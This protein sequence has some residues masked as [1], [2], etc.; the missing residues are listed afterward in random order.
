MVIGDETLKEIGEFIILLLVHLSFISNLVLMIVIYRKKQNSFVQV[1][2]FTLA[3]TLMIWNLGT[4]L[5]LDYRLITGN[6][7]ASTISIM[8][9]DICYLAI[10]FEPIVILFLGRVIYQHDWHP[11]MKHMALFIIPTISFMMVCTNPLHN[12]FFKNFSLYSSEAV[13]GPYYYF[14]SLYSYGCIL[15]GLAF[16]VVFAFR[17]SGILSKQFFMIVF[18]IIIPLTGNVLFSFGFADL[19]FS[20]NACLFTV[21][22]IC[23]FVAIFKY[24]FFAVTPIDM[25]QVIDLI[26]EGFLQTDKSMKIVDYNNMLISL[27]PNTTLNTQEITLDEFFEQ[28]ELRSYKNECEEL[29]N[30]SKKNRASANIH[31]DLPDSNHFT[32]QITPFFNHD[33]YTGSIV[34]FKNIMRSKPE[35]ETDLQNALNKVEENNR[36]LSVKIEENIARF[37]EDRQASQAIYD[38]NPQINFIIDLEYNIIDCNPAALEFYKFANKDELKK[39]VIPMLNS[40]IPKKMPN[41]A[42]SIPISKRL[43]DAYNLGETSFDTL[44]LFDGEEIPFHFDLKRVQYKNAGVIAVYQTDLRELKKIEK[45]LEQRDMLLSAINTVSARL[46][47]VENEDFDKSFGESIAMLGRSIDVERVVVWKNFERDGA[48]YCTQIHEWCE[49]AERQHGMPHT[50]NIKYSDTVPTWETTLRQGKCVNSISKNLLPIEKA[51][52]ELQGI[53]SVLAVPLFVR[54]MFW[55]FVGFDDC[56]NERVFSEM[57]ESTLGSGAML[58]AAAL[59]RNEMTNN[60]IVAKDDALSSARAKSTFLANMSHEIRTP[61]NAIIGMTTIAKNATSPQK[62]S[63]CLSE[64]SIASTHLL[65]VINDILDVSKIEAE[66][67]ELAR[68]EFDFMETIK[69]ITTITAESIKRKKQIFEIDC[70]PNIPKRLIGDDLRFSQIITNFLSNAI[71]FTP[72]HGKIGLE[73]KLT[74]DNGDEVELT[75]A[76]TDTGIGISPEQQQ[77]L[78]AAFEQADRSTSRKYGGTGLGLVIS[79]NIIMQMGGNVKVTSEIGKGSR[80]EFNVFLTKGSDDEAYVENTV[81]EQIEKFDYTGKHILLVEDVDINREII[82]ALL[83]DTNITIDCAENGLAGAEKFLANQDKY[84]LIF[85][86]IQM[87]LMDGFDATKKIRAADTPKAKSVPIVAMTANAFKEDVEKCRECGMDDHIAKPIDLNIILNKLHKYII[88]R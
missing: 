34:I 14:H 75:V 69:K 40:V 51:Q 78:F 8:L 44:L 15:V 29:Y 74:S 45:D 6:T 59:F 1:I 82:I 13:Y 86:D 20:I 47:S 62:I 33:E 4:M 26:S 27:F 52:M 61:M 53:I 68:D 64:I 70:D 71:K 22:S 41:G 30:H 87:P 19:P 5:E 80:F 46:V 57:E 24:Q 17:S 55:G 79:K 72:E 60:L 32:M 2:S 9:I 66:K 21:S 54:D 76:V 16:L 36:N 50:I 65:G 38:S 11:K 88:A 58:I 81:P 77:H 7:V 67:F 39:N 85:M 31:I 28:S 3:F 63:E 84:D 56:V 42:D 12:L 35:N 18:S 10:C 23:I 37:E 43:A 48:L 25:R 83:E 73:A 49:G